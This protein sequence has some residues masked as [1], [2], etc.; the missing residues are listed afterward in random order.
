MVRA[1]LGA[2][3]KGKAAPAAP[4]P[5]ASSSGGSGGRPGTASSASRQGLPQAH[6]PP[7]R[8]QGD[9]RRDE[10]DLSTSPYVTSRPAQ[11]LSEAVFPEARACGGTCWGREACQSEMVSVTDDGKGIGR[12]P[13]KDLVAS[14]EQSM[15]G[16]VALPLP[17]P[18]LISHLMWWTDSFGQSCVSKEGR[19]QM[20]LGRAWTAALVSA[21]ATTTMVGEGRNVANGALKLSLSWPRTCYSSLSSL[22]PSSAHLPL[23]SASFAWRVSGESSCVAGRHEGEGGEDA[24]G[25]VTWHPPW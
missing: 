13:E 9:I 19:W 1:P 5:A 21:N 7:L 18:S 14:L 15:Q 23:S 22:S 2:G 24:G 4:Q 20:E 10:E 11:W 6:P 16:L 8:G 25:A 17:W 12:N 3:G